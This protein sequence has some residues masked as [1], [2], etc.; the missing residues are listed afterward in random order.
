MASK[1]RSSS[2]EATGRGSPEAVE[3]RRSARQLNTL[4]GATGEKKLDGRTEKRR[5]RL[6]KELK[7][8]RRGTALKP[9]DFVSH[10]HELL[11]I[12]ES[13]SSLRKQG[14]K[15][16]KTDTSPEVLDAVERTQKAYGF[17]ADAWKMLGITLEASKRGRRGGRRKKA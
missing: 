10:V 8:G 11:E 7:Q 12:G 2:K 1:K 5:K 9:I 6:V 15:A 14:V 16:R 3:K 17:R 4:L 13:L